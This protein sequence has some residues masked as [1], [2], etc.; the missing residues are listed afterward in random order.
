[1]QCECIKPHSHAA[2]TA[3]SIF[4]LAATMN[5]STITAIM[6]GNFA[7]VHQVTLNGKSGLYIVCVAI[8]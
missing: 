6:I 7:N 8:P 5:Q 4:L 3:M 2:L 1:M